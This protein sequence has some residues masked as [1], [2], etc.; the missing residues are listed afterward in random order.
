MRLLQL[1]SIDAS[2]PTCAKRLQA[3]VKVTISRSR[4]DLILLIEMTSVNT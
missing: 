3:Q 1:P 2:D 4:L